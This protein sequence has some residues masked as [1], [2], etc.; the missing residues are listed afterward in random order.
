MDNVMC[1]PRFGRIYVM[2]PLFQDTQGHAGCSSTVGCR[3]NLLMLSL[4]DQS[5]RSLL[6][7]L[8]IQLIAAM[9]VCFMVRPYLEDDPNPKP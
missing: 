8:V 5:V 3:V 6:F 7:L 4:W 1:H 2:I 9:I